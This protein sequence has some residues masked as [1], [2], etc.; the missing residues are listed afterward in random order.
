MSPRHLLLSG[1]PTLPGG[2]GARCL[3]KLLT[4]SA[5]AWSPV[6]RGRGERYASRR[7]P[8]QGRGSR[9]A[10]QKVSGAGGKTRAEPGT[11]ETRSSL[12]QLPQL[13]SLCALTLGTSRPR[14]CSSRPGNLSSASP[15]EVPL[16]WKWEQVPRAG[17]PW[18]CPLVA[19]P[20][21]A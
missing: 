5:T 15:A 9:D 21:L 20:L 13:G 7:Q 12:L 4:K 18:S 17:C 8:G 2:S 16:C 11:E 14:P 19:Q 3:R 6:A 10:A 1:G